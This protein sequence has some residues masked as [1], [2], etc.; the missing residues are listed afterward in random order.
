MIAEPFLWGCEEP[1]ARAAAVK[2]YERYLETFDVVELMYPG[3][4]SRKPGDVWVDGR[5]QQPAS[6]KRWWQFR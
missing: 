6:P 4:H 1:P 5:W 3:I 2:R